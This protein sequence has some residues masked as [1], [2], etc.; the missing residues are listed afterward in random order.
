[1]NPPRTHSTGVL[2]PSIVTIHPSAG[3]LDCTHPA[4][5][6]LTHRPKPRRSG[7][8]VQGEATASRDASTF[9]EESAASPSVLEKRPIRAA[10]HELPLWS[11]SGAGLSQ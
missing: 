1:M 8:H 3:S 10:V 4:A 9:H 11:E 7:I 2:F 5:P 6:R